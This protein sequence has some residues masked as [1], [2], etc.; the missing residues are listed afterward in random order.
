MKQL[1]Q[2]IPNQPNLICGVGDYARLLSSKLEHKYGVSSD[3][4]IANTDKEIKNN[5][6]KNYNVDNFLLSTVQDFD[7]LLIHFS[8]YGYHAKG[9]PFWLPKFMRQFRKVYPLVPIIT[10]FH[11]LFIDARL[12]SGLGI[13]ARLQEY[14]ARRTAALSDGIRTNRKSAAKW[15]ERVTGRSDVNCLPVFSNL[16]ESLQPPLLSNRENSLLLFQPS[17]QQSY[18]EAYYKVIR[19]VSPDK[20]II[21]GRCHNL[22]DD[23]IKPCSIIGTV[24]TE[25]ASQLFEKNQFILHSYL[26]G[27]LAKSGI[28]AT[29]ASHGMC[30]I[31]SSSNNSIQDGII[32]GEHFLTSDDF[33]S[34]SDKLTTQRI[35]SNLHAWYQSHNTLKT[36]DSYFTQ[37][38]QVR[39]LKKV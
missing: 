36:A 18:W 7:L 23:L 8:G 34:M 6:A 11:E 9:L 2:L 39:K 15:L 31:L 30:C 14:I 5:C 26:D 13:L 20:V 17:N 4:L 21:A 38:T 16:G 10:M 12:P 19:R 28:I 22:P 29:A 35:A 25:Q 3:Y 1:L 37:F 33:I 32:Q 27:Y 24:S